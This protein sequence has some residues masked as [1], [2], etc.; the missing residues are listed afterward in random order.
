MTLTKLSAIFIKPFPGVCPALVPVPARQA[1]VLQ[2]QQDDAPLAGG[3][4]PQPSPCRH[5]LGVYNR[6][7]RGEAAIML[8]GTVL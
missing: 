4:I 3:G 6:Q 7:G 2:P 5:A 8:Q 1:A